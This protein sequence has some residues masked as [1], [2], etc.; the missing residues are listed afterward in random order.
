MKILANG[1]SMGKGN[2][3]PLPNIRTKCEG[4]SLAS[5]R[6]HRKFL[7]SIELEKL[8]G[9]GLALTL[10]V[11]DVPPSAED[12]E[13]TRKAWVRKM[14]KAGAIRLT[15]VMEWQARRAPHFHV[16]TYFP[17]A[18]PGLGKWC[19]DQWRQVA[20]KYRPRVVGQKATPIT[21]ANGWNQ[22]TSKHLQKSVRDYQRSNDNIPPEWDGTGR[23]WGRSGTWP[24][25]EEQEIDLRKKEFYR[26]RRVAHRLRRAQARSSRNPRRISR[27]R[28]SMKRSPREMSAHMGVNMWMPREQSQRLVADIQSRTA[29][30]Y[31]LWINAKAG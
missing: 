28:R 23:L 3:N 12:L 22:Y 25:G 29:W 19:L 10:T 14:L 24:I 27:S 9:V 1:F 6:S 26:V 18:R 21:D 7:Q 17:E 16:A 13:K 2:P 4:W 11:R 8:T 15:Y 31:Q 20:A 30:E 5:A